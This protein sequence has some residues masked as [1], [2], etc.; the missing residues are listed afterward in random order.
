M[1]M[2]GTFG[3]LG[4]AAR[5][6]RAAG[7]GPDLITAGVPPLSRRVIDVLGPRVLTRVEGRRVADGAELHQALLN[8][9]L[10][11][12]AT[13]PRGA[14]YDRIV[15]GLNRLPRPLMVLGSMALFGYGVA[16]PA[17]FA[18][19]MD[20]L[21]QM[22]DQLW[23]LLGAVVSLFFGA[24]EAH[25]FR[26]KKAMEV[27]F[28]DDPATENAATEPK[29]AGAENPIAATSFPSP[30]P[31]APEP[32]APP[33]VAARGTAPDLPSAAGV[34]DNPALAEWLRLEAT[35]G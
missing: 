6:A 18:Q 16:D 20:G 33:A 8:S 7:V 3:T 29:K 35:R 12:E 13:A 22:P 10:A 23:W 1:G 11:A 24:R 14:T 31:A 17:G 5:I 27:L 9:A 21:R 4:R 34:A 25:H 30:A 32:A 26:L 15:D 19:R 2:I 28:P